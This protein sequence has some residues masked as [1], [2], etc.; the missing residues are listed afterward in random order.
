V[1]AITNDLGITRM[2]SYRGVGD[3]KRERPAVLT[4]AVAA[5]L[6]LM[7]TSCGGGEE[8]QTSNTPSARAAPPNAARRPSSAGRGPIIRHGRLAG[9]LV[10]EPGAVKPGDEVGIAVKNIGSAP[11]YY[12]LRGTVERRA[13]SRWVS[14]NQAVYGTRTPRI[15]SVLWKVPAGKTGGP[16]HAGLGDR[17]LLP[18]NLQPGNYRLI[19][20]VKSNPG[21]AHLAYAKLVARFSVR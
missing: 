4:G 17:L 12:G 18:G 15:Y 2:A 7:L 14:A 1:T 20:K 10:L 21:R 3:H 8:G 13:R 6:V 5:A 19:K 9:R 11:I 16:T